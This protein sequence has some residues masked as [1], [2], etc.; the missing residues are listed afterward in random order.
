[1]ERT[2]CDRD[3]SSSIKTLNGLSELKPAP[4]IDIHVTISRDIEHDAGMT[5]V[6]STLTRTETDSCILIP[7]EEKQ[8]A[9]M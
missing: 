3:F 5:T 1:M 9:V 2:H 4:H 8:T 6:A 7:E